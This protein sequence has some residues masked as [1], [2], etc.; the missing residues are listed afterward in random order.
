[1]LSA[2]N[3]YLKI[4]DNSI[5]IRAKLAEKIEE[6]VKST[7]S[8]LFG[9]RSR[10]EVKKLLSQV[11]LR[12]EIEVEKLLLTIGRITSKLL[13]YF[14]RKTVEKEDLLLSLILYY[15][16]ERKHDFDQL[17]E[18]L[19]LLDTEVDL[20]MLLNQLLHHGFIEKAGEFYK[21]K[22]DKLF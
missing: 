21:V 19:R 14:K 6:L 11:I 15:L 22:I 9:L 4:F 2:K 13:M 20:N 5:D 17:D 12:E 8:S 18:K 7:F 1:M 10:K 3:Q 16:S